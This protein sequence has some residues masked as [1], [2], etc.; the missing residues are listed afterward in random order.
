M[1]TRKS[2]HVG[3]FEGIATLQ[4]R[5]QIALIS[6]YPKKRLQVFLD[7]FEKHGASFDAIYCCNTGTSSSQTNHCPLQDYTQIV[8]DFLIPAAEVSSRVTVLFEAVGDTVCVA[9]HEC[10]KKNIG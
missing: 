6:R 9:G 5:Y 7:H 3:S 8:N 10:E 1:K 2:I 4:A